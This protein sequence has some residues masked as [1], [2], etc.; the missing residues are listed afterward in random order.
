MLVRKVILIFSKR[1]LYELTEI[2]ANLKDN[3]KTFE[4]TGDFLPMATHKNYS[5]AKMSNK[6]NDFR[7]R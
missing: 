5:K 6:T 1:K 4:I 3:G 7:K 2:Q